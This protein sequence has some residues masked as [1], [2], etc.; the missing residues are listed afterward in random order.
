MEINAKNQVQGLETVTKIS[1]VTGMTRSQ[2]PGHGTENANLTEEEAAR[3][4]QQTA[5]QL[6][7]TNAS[8]SNQAMQKAVDLFT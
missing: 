2:A 8:I 5:E 6:S 4:S 1:E 3:V 7:Q